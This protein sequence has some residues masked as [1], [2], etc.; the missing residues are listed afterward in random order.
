[1]LEYI[2]MILT[3]VSFDRTLF[4]KELGKAV[5]KLASNELSE[6]RTWCYTHFSESYLDILERLFTGF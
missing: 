6:L 1:M 3:K 2:K 5:E 4:E